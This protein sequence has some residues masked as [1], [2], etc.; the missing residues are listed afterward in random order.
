MVAQLRP[1]DFAEVVKFKSP[2]ARDRVS[3]SLT[4]DTSWFIYEVE[5]EMVGLCG[6]MRRK[7]GGRIKGVWVKPG[8][9]RQGHGRAMTDALIAL[10]TKENGWRRLEA[11]AHHPGFYEDL[12]WQRVGAVRPNG[13]VM[14]SG[15]Y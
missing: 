13:A 1:A 8:H 2:A 5:G 11:Y 6:L 3:I 9:R 7:E 12:G 4:R 10:A 14:L 15:V